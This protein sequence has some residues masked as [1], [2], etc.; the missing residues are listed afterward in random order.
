MKR[1]K[2]PVGNCPLIEGKGGIKRI[3]SSNQLKFIANK[4]KNNEKCL[5]WVMTTRCHAT[6]AVFQWKNFLHRLHYIEFR[7]CDMYARFALFLIID[8]RIDL[9]QRLS[10][11][12]TFLKFYFHIH[13]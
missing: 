5:H 8:L 2:F 12:D 3:G 13:V 1:N 9:Y 6:I 7:L 11:A 4:P 10:I